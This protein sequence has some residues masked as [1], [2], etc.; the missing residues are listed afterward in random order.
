MSQGGAGQGVWPS[1][2][3]RNRMEPNEMERNGNKQSGSEGNKRK[4]EGTERTLSLCPFLVLCPL[5]LG[6]IAKVRPC[7]APWGVPW[8]KARKGVFHSAPFHA[9]K[10]RGLIWPRCVTERHAIPPSFV[11]SRLPMGR[12]MGGCCKPPVLF[13]GCF[14]RAVHQADVYCNMALIFP[15]RKS[16]HPQHWGT[17]QKPLKTTHR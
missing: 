6:Y 3:E 2:F 12:A 15:G 7:S 16:P 8:V 13:R 17:H 5:L 1:G 10:G 11:T 4:R 14:A 9:E